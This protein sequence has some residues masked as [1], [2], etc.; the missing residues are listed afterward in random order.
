MIDIYGDEFVE[1]EVSEKFMKKIIQIEKQHM[2]KHPKRRMTEK[3]LD[4]MF[5][6]R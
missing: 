5:E 6:V 2:N 4:K 3:E 1:K